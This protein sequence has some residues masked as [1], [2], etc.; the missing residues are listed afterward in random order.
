MEAPLLCFSS[1]RFQVSERHSVP[2]PCHA[3]ICVSVSELKAP[4]SVPARS[5]FRRGGAETDVAEPWPNAVKEGWKPWQPLPQSLEPPVPCSPLAPAPAASTQRVVRNPIAEFCTVHVAGPTPLPFGQRPTE[6]CA[7]V[8][9][10][11][12]QRKQRKTEGKKE[13]EAEAGAAVGRAPEA[14]GAP[15]DGVLPPRPERGDAG[16][17]AP[18]P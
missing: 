11:R 13:V 9:N 8:E 14:H 16:P 7:A 15:P 3:H 10:R 12:K 17:P 2:C 6:A 1:E 18:P 5:S 4:W